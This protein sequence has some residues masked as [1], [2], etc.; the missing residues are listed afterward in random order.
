[1][2][3]S[4]AKWLLPTFDL[5]PDGMD[6]RL[7]ARISRGEFAGFALATCITIGFI[8]FI[9]P[10]VQGLAQD[11]RHMTDTAHG[12]FSGYYYPYWFLPLWS[13][14]ALLPAPAAFVLSN[15]INLVGILIACRVFNSNAAIALGS[16]QTLYVMYYSQTTG[17]L[18]GGFALMFWAMQHK[19]Y[20]LAGL[21]LAIALIK[22]QIAGPLALTLWLTQEGLLTQK[23]RVA[24]IPLIVGIVSLVVYPL[25]PLEVLQRLKEIPPFSGGSIVLWQWIGPISLLLWIPVVLVPLSRE[26]RLVAVACATAL[27]TPYFQQSELLM[28]FMLPVG[29]LGLLGNFGFLM[30]AFNYAALRALVFVPLVFYGWVFFDHFVYQHRHISELASAPETQA[31]S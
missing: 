12:D 1:M 8:Y 16:Y 27:A 20:W 5:D 2:L 11:L 21:G 26:R 6:E 22:P 23:L 3:S 31:T 30:A 4:A 28:L 9:D 24:V 10:Q 19:R 18:L 25:W 13:T 17:I 29:R 14:F 7:K 15:I